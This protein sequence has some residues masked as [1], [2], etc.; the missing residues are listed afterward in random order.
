M[1]HTLFQRSQLSLPLRE[2]HGTTVKYGR[3]RIAGN[4]FWRISIDH[5]YR[6]LNF[7]ATHPVRCYRFL[8]VIM[9]MI[10]LL[11][12]FD[13]HEGTVGACATLIDD[14]IYGSP[15]LNPIFMPLTG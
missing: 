14:F 4:T 5:L 7:L 3:H 13:Y 15:K 9:L 10:A 12:K 1:R 2:D 6:I 8:F 11:V